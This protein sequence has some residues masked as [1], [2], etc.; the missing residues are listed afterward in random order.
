M[1]GIY[2][3]RVT[4]FEVLTIKLLNTKHR[5]LRQTES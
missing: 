5:E 2:G 1:Y 3:N 4:V